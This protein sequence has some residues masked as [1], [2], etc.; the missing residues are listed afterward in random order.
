MNKVTECKTLAY[1]KGNMTSFE[2]KHAKTIGC[3]IS[4]GTNLLR[5]NKAENSL[6][7]T[8]KPKNKLNKFATKKSY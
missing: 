3:E 4:I 8:F 5:G 1:R 6:A 7:E 2:T